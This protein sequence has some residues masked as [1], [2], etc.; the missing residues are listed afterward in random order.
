MWWHMMTQGGEVEGKL[1]NGVGSRYPSHYLGT[2]C[3]Q[4][5]YRWCAHLG[6]QQ[7][8]ELTPTGRFKWTRPFRRRTK[9]GFCACVITFQLAFPWWRLC[10][11]AALSSST[12]H[13]TVRRPRFQLAA[14]WTNWDLSLRSTIQN[15]SIHKVNWF[16][17][18][19]PALKSQNSVL[20]PR[21]VFM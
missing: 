8:T 11:A 21:S 13:S 18:V 16:L 5:Y 20:W 17:Y 7:S 12:F 1:V 14:K 9:T 2:W 19:P 6:C 10:P 15:K 3:I 4:H